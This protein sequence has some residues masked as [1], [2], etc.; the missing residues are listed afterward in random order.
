MPVDEREFLR[1]LMNIPAG[2]DE[3]LER[4]GRAL[5]AES[6]EN[7]QRAVALWRSAG[8]EVADRMRG[9]LVEMAEQTILPL[10]KAV[11]MQEP[12]D[13]V[14]LLRR[15]TEQFLDLRTAVRDRLIGL[16]DDHTLVP[17]APRRGPSEV[18]PPPVRIC[19]EAYLQ[20]RRILNLGESVEDKVVNSDVFLSQLDFAERSIEIER[21]K[22]SGEFRNFVEDGVE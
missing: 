13:T 20:L 17:L 12:R 11:P 9:V 6:R 3:K 21:F 7:G 22:K 4:V 14:W 5:L 16:L 2:D 8:A 18:D 19:D 10:L 1:G 15:A